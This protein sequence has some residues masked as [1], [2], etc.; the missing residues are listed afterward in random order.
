MLTFSSR[1][2]GPR[3]APLP[4]TPESLCSC[5]GCASNLKSFARQQHNESTLTPA[6]RLV[7]SVARPLRKITT[8][9]VDGDLGVTRSGKMAGYDRPHGMG[10]VMEDLTAGKPP[11]IASMLEAK[12]G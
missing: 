10:G 9:Y 12:R 7:N 1:P 11:E 8:N 2:R 3:D 6:A 4:R 5:D